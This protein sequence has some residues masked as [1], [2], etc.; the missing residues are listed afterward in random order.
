MLSRAER[1]QLLVAPTAI[2]V[3]MELVTMTDELRLI[4]GQNLSTDEM[5]RVA[6]ILN[7]FSSV[8]ICMSSIGCMCSWTAAASSE[9]LAVQNIMA[10]IGVHELAL[11]LLHRPH[12]DTAHDMNEAVLRFLCSVCRSGSEGNVSR[13]IIEF[14]GLYT[15]QLTGAVYPWQYT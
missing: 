4:S 8:C 1:I 6:S 15:L 12:E 13:I 11:E 7:H 14:C 10:N 2:K 9:H 3:H 5:R